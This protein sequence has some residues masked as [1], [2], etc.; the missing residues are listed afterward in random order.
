MKFSAALLVMLA[1]LSLP[2]TS[3]STDRK[4]EVASIKPNKS[5]SNRVNLNPLPGLRIIAKCG[6]RRG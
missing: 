4:F 3:Q 1:G 6:T 5:G 2:V